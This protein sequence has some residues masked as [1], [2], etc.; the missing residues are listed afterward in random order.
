MK[1]SFRINRLPAVVTF[2][3]LWGF[4]AVAWSQ[5]PEPPATPEKPA[6]ARALRPPAAAGGAYSTAGPFVYSRSFG[7]KVGSAQGAEADRTLI[8]P[9]NKGEGSAQMETQEDMAVMDHIL[10]KAISTPDEQNAVAMGIRIRYPF[11]SPSLPS[12]FY[13]EGY[14]AVFLLEVN[15]PLRPSTAQ[16]GDENEE[17]LSEWDEARHEVA[18]PNSYGASVVQVPQF[19][20]E[21]GSPQYDATRVEGL[22][23]NVAKALKNASHIRGLKPDETI[24][25]VITGRAGGKTTVS[26]L[27]KPNGAKA[28]AGSNHTASTSA[29]LIFRATKADIDTFQSSKMDA[30]EFIKEK[31]VVF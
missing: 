13:L 3:A 17:A 27:R 6:P 22:K 12:N 31:L 23:R 29:K 24:T 16:E 28:G 2:M 30:E 11:N 26:P 7:G 19:P 25:V 4:G 21:G 18:N 10:Q 14:G 1:T 8:I 15:Y 5:D 9:K 20:S